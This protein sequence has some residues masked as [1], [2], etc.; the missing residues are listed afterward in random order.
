M[1]TCGLR[2]RSLATLGKNSTGGSLIDTSASLLL[3]G[4]EGVD[5]GEEIPSVVTT[6]RFLY[7]YL[8]VSCSHSLSLLLPQCSTCSSCSTF[9]AT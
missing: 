6:A 3:V 9:H 1:A 2:P 4:E 7:R 5:T 8:L